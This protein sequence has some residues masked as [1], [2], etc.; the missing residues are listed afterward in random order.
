MHGIDALGYPLAFLGELQLLR[1]FPV[2]V[3]VPDVS[4]VDKILYAGVRRTGWR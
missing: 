3:D 4:L 1:G 2:D